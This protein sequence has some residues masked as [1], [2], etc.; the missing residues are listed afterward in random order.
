MSSGPDE[1]AFTIFVAKNLSCTYLKRDVAVSSKTSVTT[2]RHIL[3]YVTLKIH[4][5][6]DVRFNIMADLLS[7]ASLVYFISDILALFE[8]DVSVSP[9]LRYTCTFTRRLES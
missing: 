8:V 3:K 6:N 4:C 2:G 1:P 5:R 9:A 7:L